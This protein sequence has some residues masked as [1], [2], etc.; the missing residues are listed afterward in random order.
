[1]FTVLL[2]RFVGYNT[3]WAAGNIKYFMIII[4]IFVITIDYVVNLQEHLFI[5]KAMLIS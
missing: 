5:T 2:I 3:G 4:M 1:M